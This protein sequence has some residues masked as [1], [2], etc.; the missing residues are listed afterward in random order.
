MAE[1]RRGFGVDM[2]RL[3]PQ[4]RKQSRW[5]GRN[6]ERACAKMTKGVV[7]GRSK[8]V[9]VGDNFIQV[10]CQKPPD[11]VAPPYSFEVKNRPFPKSVSDAMSQAISNC[12]AGLTP[13]LWWRDRDTGIRYLI[14]IVKDFIDDHI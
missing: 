5:R 2:S 13:K 1:K 10:N 11:V 3:T 14:E 4:A 6:E 8:A 9:R 7:V 12:P